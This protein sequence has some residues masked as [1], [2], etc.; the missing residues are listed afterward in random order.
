MEKIVIRNVNGRGILLNYLKEFHRLDSLSR[1]IDSLM[2]DYFK[3]QRKLPK[4]V[5]DA[6]FDL[7]YEF[8]KTKVRR[9]KLMVYQGHNIRSMIK[10]MI[11][12]GVESKSI[13]VAV[14]AELKR[15]NFNNIAKK[16]IKVI[17]ENNKAS[18]YDLLKDALKEDN[19]L[20][21]MFNKMT[22]LNIFEYSSKKLAV[23]SKP[24]RLRKKDGFVKLSKE[25][26]QG[27]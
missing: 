4:P 11:M 2:I 24:V 8:N 18:V 7:D 17:R 20:I 13:M 26:Q 1:A 19:Y 3:K 6:L 21:R 14:K 22:L 23:R 5:H 25:E 27:E 16:E 15:T 9:T 10:D 12:K